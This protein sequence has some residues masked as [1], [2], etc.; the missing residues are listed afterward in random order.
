[1]TLGKMSGAGPTLLAA[2]CLFNLT[3]AAAS[4]DDLA[5]RNGPLDIQLHL[6][7]SAQA[8]DVS[9]D[10]ARR[11]DSPDAL[12][13]VAR[14]TADWT[15]STGRL[16][17][18]SLETASGDR[19]TEAL[20]S[21]E[22]YAYLASDFGRIELGKQD[23][24]ADQLAYRAPVIALGQVRGDFARYA[25]APAALS[26]Y[27]SGDAPKFIYLSPPLAGFRVGAS[28]APRDDRD[29]DTLAARTR[30]R[31][32]VELGAQY[33]RPVGD[34]IVGGSAGW[35][36]GDSDPATG[37]ADIRSWSAGAQARR[38]PLKVG[39]GYVDRGDSN[40]SVIGFGQTE[41]SAGVSWV[42]ERW[43]VA[44][45]AAS[46]DASTFS[47]RPIGIGGYYALTSWATIRADLVRIDQQRG[48]LPREDGFVFVSE[49][50]LHY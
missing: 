19:Q 49:L 6:A 12:E 16:F 47:N 42:K 26:A 31:D 15:T 28:Y 50:A 46:S 32:V 35:V 20:N 17:G 44:L 8:G 41:W 13:G 10:V 25:G 43:G 45:S 39:V 1:M 36:H 22:V 7:V 21:G 34:W 3:P 4:A 14:L 38:G 23:G 29:G 30:Q 27:D 2:F 11:P 9:G 37:K 18:F 5:Y 33:E 40:Q 48:A 24:A